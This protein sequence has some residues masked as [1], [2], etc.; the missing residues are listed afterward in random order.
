MEASTEERNE[1]QKLTPGQK[2]RIQEAQE[3]LR[4]ADEQKNEAE[5]RLFYAIMEAYHPEELEGRTPSRS[6]SRYTTP[7]PESRRMRSRRDYGSQEARSSGY[8]RSTPG[9]SSDEERRADDE[10]QRMDEEN[11]RTD[12]ESQETHHYGSEQEEPQPRFNVFD[13]SAQREDDGQVPEDAVM[14]DEERAEEHRE[15][16]L[17]EYRGPGRYAE[18]VQ[19]ELRGDSE[20]YE[21]EDLHDG[22]EEGGVRPESQEGDGRDEDL[23]QDE[24]LSV[25][26]DHEVHVGQHIGPIE[27]NQ[28]LGEQAQEMEPDLEPEANAG[29]GG[30]PPQA[31][32]EGDPQPPAPEGEL[33]DHEVLITPS[34]T[35]YHLSVA[36]PTLANTRRILRSDWCEHCSR[37]T[38]MVRRPL[39][40]VVRPGG[41]AHLDSH[42]PHVGLRFPVPY[43][44]CQMCPRRPATNRG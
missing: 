44:C 30:V 40:H 24:E 3:R 28:G 21:D 5:K 39:L 36:C 38:P 14:E 8:E 32:G 2:R 11:R 41:E 20:P 4:E 17:P 12:E 22:R 13:P 16:T 43:Q 26:S 27:R 23:L 1:D 15:V 25:T 42:C 29:V 6:L 19:R 33:P 9:R 35:R 31:E 37:R 34:G 7:T 10:V 18:D